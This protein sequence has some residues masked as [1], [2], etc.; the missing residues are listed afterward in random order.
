LLKPEVERQIREML[1]LGIIVPSSSEMASPVVCV[2]KGRDGQKGVRLAI[3]YRHVNLHS[4][5]DCFPTPDIGDVLQRVGSAKYISCFDAKSGYWQLSEKRESRWLTAFVCDA[6]LFE[7]Q[8]LPFGLKSAGN[9]FM[10]CVSRILHPV[11]SFTEPFVD[12]MAVYSMAWPEHLDHLERFLGIIKE[13]GLTLNL[14]KCAFARGQTSFVGHVIGSGIIA[15]DPIKIAS[16]EYIQPPSTKKDVRR[17]IGF[18]SYFR[19]FIP[20]LA[21]T[22]RIITDLTQKSVPNNVP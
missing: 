5:G 14:K 11:R 8:R 1:D 21:E 9:T 17:L 19:N 2:L 15:P 10:R 16:V 3:D 7:F 18:F 13:S 6:G 4:A 20:S 22:A 12:D